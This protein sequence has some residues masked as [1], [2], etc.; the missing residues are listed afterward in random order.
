MSSPPAAAA[1]PRNPDATREALL[2]EAFDQMY[3]KG[4]HASGLK[5][6]LAASG[7]TKGALYHHFG[8][9]LELGYAVVEER[10]MPLVRDRYLKPFQQVRDPVVAVDRMGRRMEQELLREGVL[11]RGCPLNNLV[12][13]MSGADEGFRG[14]LEAILDEWRETVA[15]GLRQGQSQGTIDGDADPRAAAT[16]VVASL[17]GAVGFAKNARDVA[18]FHACRRAVNAYVATL[19]SDPPPSTS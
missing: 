14:R 2:D 13:E 5:D 11:D 4:F 12:Q 9:K 17:L 1:P 8:S 18:P 10:V 7:L 19:R 6:I 15:E 16:F 3:A